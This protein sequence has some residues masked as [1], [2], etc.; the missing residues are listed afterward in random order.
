MLLIY[1]DHLFL[2]GGDELI[3]KAKRRLAT[4]FQMKDLLIMHYFLGMEV[5]QS[6]DGIF[7]GQG[8]Y[9][10][11]ILKR[12]IMLD[13]NSMA[14]PMASNL[15]LQCDASSDMVDAMM[16]CQMIGSLMYLTNTRLDICFAVNT[17]SQ[18][19]M[20]LIHVHLIIANHVL[21]YL[22]GT[23]DYGLKYDVTNNINLPSYVDSD[24]ARN[25]TDRKSTSGRCFSLGSGTISWFNK[26]Q[27]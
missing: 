2:V 17:L 19:L 13:Y 18:F 8:K 1:V 12:F 7:L 4:K 23:V 5:L 24:W 6:A 11:D 26:K 21:R 22:K 9:V 10:M 25:T 27:S 14:T 15:N 16:Y 3:K 20:D